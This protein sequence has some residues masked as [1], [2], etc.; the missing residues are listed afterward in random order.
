M[1]DG[2]GSLD[3]LLGVRASNLAPGPLGATT[4]RRFLHKAMT[5]TGGLV[6][7]P[8][9][10]LGL[11][12]GRALANPA[13]PRRFLF[14]YFEGGWD[15][16][17]ALD[18][19][20]P[21]TTRPDVHRIDPAYAQTAVRARGIQR[22]GDLTFGPAV[23]PAFLRHAGRFS[24]V[25]GINMDTAAHEVGR[26]YFITGQRPRGL[27]AVGS[28][29]AAEVAAHLGDLSAI[30]YL[31]MAVEAYALDL[32]SFAR[33]LSVASL[34][35]LVVAL[36]PFS[37]VDPAVLA[38]LRAFQ[39]APPSCTAERLDRDGL[40]TTLR[41]SQQRAR[42]YIEGQIARLFDLQRS[43]PEMQTLRARYGIEG[44][45]NP[46][47]P[48]VLGFAAGQALK[49]GTS[50]VVSVRV[51]EGL[52]TH[53]AWAAD[54]PGRLEQGFL[55]LA[56]LLDDLAETESPY[57]S[58]LLDHTTVVAFSEFSRTPLLNSLEGRDHFLGNSCLVSGPGLVEGRVIGGSAEIGMMPVDLEPTTG[59]PRPDATLEMRAAGAVVPIG[60]GHVLAAV[61]RSAGAP[62]D[63]LREA[64]LPA[65]LRT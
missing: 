42:A 40:A 30:P 20:D 38:A 65:L 57:G 32:P 1:I 5:L 37:E 13:D 36:T 44:V 33:P 16:L 12:G 62:H 60:P 41:E 11:G 54:H 15:Q 9:A 23:P 28:S 47:D 22:V 24:I 63:Q 27:A 64:P 49:S 2:L 8:P 48:R 6:L 14:A 7:G 50:Q 43:D 35:D 61:L 55:V 18:P 3:R 4:R 25:R 31:A 52:D 59:R 34:N 58:S 26:R 53:S 51:A 10:G 56:A 21:A 39:D 29:V 45:S 46:V 19:R 17:L